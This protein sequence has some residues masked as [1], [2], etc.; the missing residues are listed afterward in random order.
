MTV[1]VV[2][3]S[4]NPLHAFNEDNYQSVHTLRSDAQENAA[5]IAE[6]DNCP[7]FIL[8]V[9]TVTDGWYKPVTEVV[10]GSPQS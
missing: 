7:A 9:T 6:A 2:S 1:Y 8:E 5:L 10:Y 4:N 3:K